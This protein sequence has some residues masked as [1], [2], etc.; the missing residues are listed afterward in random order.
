MISQFHRDHEHVV[1]NIN[2]DCHNFR[3]EMRGGAAG[4]KGWQLLWAGAG[5]GFLIQT[6]TQE[7]RKGEFAVAKL[8]F[9]SKKMKGFENINFAYP[10]YPVGGG[11]KAFKP[12]PGSLHRQ[13]HPGLEQ[14]D[15]QLV[16]LSKVH[17]TC[18]TVPPRYYL[19]SP[20][21]APGEQHVYK[22]SQ[23]SSS[24]STTSCLSCSHKH[25]LWATAS[26]NPR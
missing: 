16:S 26:L 10:A 3:E 24:A 25:C 6:R 15:R 1:L 5:H 23:A 19:A 2:E 8:T 4:P 21:S 11:G 7:W 17:N 22:V 20:A 9:L 13:L 18:P 12:H 14:E